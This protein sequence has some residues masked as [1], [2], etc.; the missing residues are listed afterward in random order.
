MELTHE[1]K[2]VLKN[3]VFDVRANKA[4][5]SIG[6]FAGTGKTTVLKYLVKFFPNFGVAA[7]TGKAAAIIRKKGVMA[8]TIHSRI[9]KP[10]FDNGSV[11]FDLTPN[12]ECDGFFIDEASMVSADIDED[13]RSF[14]LPIVYIGDHG[15]LEPVDSKFNLMENP[16]YKLEE[17]HRNAGDIA[18]FAEHL[19]KG[20]SPRGFRGIDGSVELIYS[21]R[22]TDDQLM[23]V[24]QIICAFNKTR[25]EFNK[26]VRDVLGFNNVVEIG[27][28]VMCLKNNRKAGLFNG[29]QGKV[30]NLYTGK[31]GKRFMDFEF[32]GEVMKDVWY[33]EACF[34]QESPKIKTSKDSP[35]PFDYAY[36]VTAHKF[37]GDENLKILTVEQKCKKW[38]HK[39]WT[40]TCASR[41][42]EKLFWKL[43]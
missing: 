21:K 24:D 25:V 39:R 14:G 23:E 40:Y 33:D 31:Y 30:V 34:G 3:V 11:Y 2:T 43:A 42:K 10:F 41:A 13:L 16:D 18:R 7:F 15:Q 29:M 19:R 26:R 35:N 28:R 37:Q 9:Y 22:L 20:L 5:T 32:D 17:I 12:P 1:Q 4:I 6:G 27:D 36:C 38:S 8:T